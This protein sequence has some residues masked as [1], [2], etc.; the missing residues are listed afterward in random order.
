MFSS[1][2]ILVS[3]PTLANLQVEHILVA[4]VHLQTSQDNNQHHI[5]LED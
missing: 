5:I 1:T 2:M 3:I 4:T